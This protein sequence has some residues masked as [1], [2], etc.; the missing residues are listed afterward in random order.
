MKLVLLRLENRE[1]F[2]VEMQ[3]AFQK[4][5]TDYF[6]PTKDIVLP[7]AD[8]ENS[9]CTDG[10]VAFEVT[11]AESEERLGGCIVVI[12][13]D[14]KC[15][16]LHL[17]Y[18]KVGYQNRGAASFL[19]REIEKRFSTV[20]EWETHT[21]YFDIRNI[22]FYVNRCAFHIVEFYNDHH[23]EPQEHFSNEGKDPTGGLG[24]FRFKKMMQ[25]KE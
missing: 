19:W 13:Q 25:Y 15:G 5:Y 11:D 8:I 2:K 17:L 3:Q 1:A 16:S 23:P 6:G 21:P 12:S 14:G 24:M 4:G 18:T 20:K 22:H 10:A 7:F 9:L